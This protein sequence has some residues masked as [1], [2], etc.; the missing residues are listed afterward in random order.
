M[1]HLSRPEYLRFTWFFAIATRRSSLGHCIYWGFVWLLSSKPKFL[2][3]RTDPNVTYTYVH[4]YVQAYYV[5]PLY[6]TQFGLICCACMCVCVRMNAVYAHSHSCKEIHVCEYVRWSF[7]FLRRTRR[8]ITVIAARWCMYVRSVCINACMIVC[9]C[10]NTAYTHTAS[11]SRRCIPLYMCECMNKGYT[12]PGDACISA[13]TCAWMSIYWRETMHACAYVW[14]SLLRGITCLASIR[15]V[16][17]VMLQGNAFMCVFVCMNQAYAQGHLCEARH[18][19]A[20]VCAWIRCHK[21]SNLEMDTVMPLVHDGLIYVSWLCTPSPKTVEALYQVLG[22][23]C[24]QLLCYSHQPKY[25]AVLQ[26]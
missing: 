14:C 8:M 25:F 10:M 12:L 19:Y 2:C 9:I 22:C 24:W 13:C 1:S 23:M 6:V 4:L 18:S 16:L 20:Y 3:A 26:R 15:R 11:P 5:V 7:C 17:T 21:L